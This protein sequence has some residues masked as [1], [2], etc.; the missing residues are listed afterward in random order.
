MCYIYSLNPITQCK[1]NMDIDNHES[2]PRQVVSPKLVPMDIS[3]TKRLHEG[4]SPTR[5]LHAPKDMHTASPSRKA[6]VPE[7]SPLADN[8]DSSE[9]VSS[10]QENGMMRGRSRKS[11]ERFV[12]SSPLVAKVKKITEPSGAGVKLGDI[13]K[14][15]DKL[16]KVAVKDDALKRLHKV[17]YGSDGTA[18]TRKKQ[19]RIWN[20]TNNEATKKSMAAGLAGAKSVAMLKDICSILSLST[21][22]DRAGLEERIIDFLVKPLGS[23]APVKAKKV[24]KEKKKS[25]PSTTAGSVS[26]FSLFVKKRLPEIKAQAGSSMSARDVTELLT[27]EWASMSSSEK[28]EF[29]PNSPRKELKV[30]KVIEKSS[31]KKIESS[32]DSSS[33]SSDSSSD[34]SSDSSDSD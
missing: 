14:I 34:D 15:A 2:S 3:P 24:K 27:M 32:D 29:A 9:I 5:T 7:E 22:G 8:E 23:S 21:G 1:M 17:L 25:K 20:G 16:Y 10:S 28:A 26:S 6:R 19:I 13:T 11:T 12:G 18:T 33:S 4:G 30:H 31:M